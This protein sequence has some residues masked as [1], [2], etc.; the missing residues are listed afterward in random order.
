M[1]VRGRGGLEAPGLGQT[2]E[3]GTRW[4]NAKV[5][6][7]R[8]GDGRADGR[9]KLS[10]NLEGGVGRVGVLGDAPLPRPSG[11]KAR[12]FVSREETPHLPRF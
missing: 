5:E 11:H 9:R 8:I 1:E 4:A 10:S 3:R 12:G 2:A 7:D 6:R